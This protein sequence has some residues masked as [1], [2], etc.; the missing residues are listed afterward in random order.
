M[1]EV[2]NLTKFYGPHPAIQEVSFQVGRGEILGF[3]GPNGA[4]KTT[5]MRILTCFLPATSG[6]ARMAGFDVFEDSLEVRKR[7]G[8]LPEHVD[9][10]GEMKVSTYLDFVA[11]IKGVGKSDR[12]TRVGQVMDDV[13]ITH[14]QN[15]LVGKLSKGYRQRVGLAQAILGEPEILI[16]DEPTVGLDPKQNSE[17]RALIQGLAGEKTVVLST[18]IL[19]EVELTCE[20]VIIIDGGRVRAMDTPE[21]LRS[22]MQDTM[23]V[24]VD[25][26][27]DRSAVERTLG[28]IDGVAGVRTL[29][30]GAAGGHTFKIES[31]PHVD[32]RRA[33]SEKIVGAGFGLLQMRVE[34]ATLEDIFIKLVGKSGTESNRGAETRIESEVGS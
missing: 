14:Y 11:S 5:T 30:S 8:Y 32:V 24:L 23:T 25:V 28:E 18:H 27:G 20:R 12:K 15:F 2:E 10:Y 7:I 22:A 26:E 21:N 9:L 33:V 16:L 3:L 6:S 4:G 1:I 17:I 13:G 19:P 34:A 31:K 29:G